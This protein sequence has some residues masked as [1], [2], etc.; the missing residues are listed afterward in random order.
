MHI[1]DGLKIYIINDFR[2][3]MKVIHLDDSKEILIVGSR[4]DTVQILK[5]YLRGRYEVQ[6]ADYSTKVMLEYE[7]IHQI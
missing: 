4:R 3:V 1:C 7:I 6:I 5:S 2:Y